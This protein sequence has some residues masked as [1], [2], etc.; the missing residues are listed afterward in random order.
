[1]RVMKKRKKN[2]L[3]MNGIVVFKKTKKSATLVGCA[4]F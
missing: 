3:R 2:V 1:M 4:D